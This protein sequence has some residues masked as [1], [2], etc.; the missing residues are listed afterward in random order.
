MWNQTKIEISE[1]AKI[2][3]KIKYIVLSEV[4]ND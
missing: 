3:A 1:M 4:M 2:T